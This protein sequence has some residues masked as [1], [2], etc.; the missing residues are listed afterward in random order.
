MSSTVSPTGNAA[1]KKP[2]AVDPAPRM[3]PSVSSGSDVSMARSL[4][5]PPPT[6]GIPSDLPTQISATP[7]GLYT[8]SD[9]PN[10][11]PQDQL[12]LNL[13]LAAEA[14]LLPHG[15][16]PSA[17][18]VPPV[19]G[20]GELDRYFRSFSAHF[21]PL[22]QPALDSPLPASVP[23]FRHPALLSARFLA[24]MT[25]LKA[26]PKSQR[27]PD[28]NARLGDILQAFLDDGFAHA[29][30][31]ATDAAYAS[32]VP[33]VADALEIYPF[34]LERIFDNH[35][36]I[37]NTAIRIVSWDPP[38]PQ[39][40]RAPSPSPHEG[41][42]VLNF[43]DNLPL[44]TIRTMPPSR[45]PTPMLG[46]SHPGL[47]GSIHSPHN[48][49]P[50]PTP[51][52]PTFNTNHAA[53][54]KRAATKQPATSPPT[55]GPSARPAPAPAPA[56]APTSDTTQPAPSIPASQAPTPAPVQ[57]TA[58]LAPWS[59]M[60][61]KCPA[62]GWSSSPSIC[63][64]EVINE[65]I[66]TLPSGH[67]KARYF[68]LSA[69][70]PEHQRPSTVTITD[71]LNQSNFRITS[72]S[73]NMTG[74]NLVIF[75]TSSLST[76]DIIRLDDCV[77]IILSV[78]VTSTSYVYYSSL[79]ISQLPSVRYRVGGAS[80]PVDPVAY[81]LAAAQRS[82]SPAWR[83]LT[84]D[85]VLAARWNPSPSPDSA[86]LYVNIREDSPAFAR[87]RALH[88]GTLV[89]DLGAGSRITV[90]CPVRH[91]IL[92]CTNCQAL[93][94]PTSACRSPPKCAMCA[95]P[96]RTFDH[97]ARAAPDASIQYAPWTTLPSAARAAA[98]TPLATTYAL[99]LLS[100]PPL[101]VHRPSPTVATATRPTHTVSTSSQPPLP[102]HQLPPQPSPRVPPPTL[103]PGMGW[104]VSK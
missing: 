82:V 46:V 30:R 73:W 64:N 21:T 2:M 26:Q 88:N 92:A 104:P 4:S 31:E 40:P 14:A 45:S 96:H 55:P 76:D 53:R 67:A 5:P 100:A 48:R 34:H 68:R 38:A 93:G 22:S 69:A 101:C 16:L 54:A 18:P 27:S 36:S 42:E 8:Q 50:T 86:T 94:H 11:V 9:G 23:S 58:P 33:R 20:L 97:S 71:A 29:S 57:P 3:S 85:Q 66:S 91:G 75:P 39:A 87:L 37:I 60:A 32:H 84:T 70:I 102:T 28:D 83:A 61:A 90:V 15:P 41:H 1:S 25:K 72:A 6:L 89:F 56:L 59:T 47:P 79:S 17:S 80:E 74:R 19:S 65:K 81:L 43:I 78:P 52:V 98:A 51:A 62:T 99:A 77:S 35:P 49:P 44:A 24:A 103:R 7:A 95:G 13:N 12:A 10:P 63:I